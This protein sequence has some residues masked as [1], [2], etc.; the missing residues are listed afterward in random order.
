MTE[1][2]QKQIRNALVAAFP[3]TIPILASFLFLG[4]AYGI[5]MHVSR[6]SFLYPLF[7]SIFLFTGS[8]EFLMPTLLMASF[9]PLRIC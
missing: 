5:Y 7:L 8:V 1:R 3:H 2:N 9:E 4:L 6:F